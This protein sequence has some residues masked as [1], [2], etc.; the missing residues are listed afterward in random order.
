MATSPDTRGV[1]IQLNGS[2]NIS[3]YIDSIELLVTAA[4]GPFPFTS[5]IGVYDSITGQPLGS[6][7]FEIPAAGTLI[8]PIEEEYLAQKVFIGYDASIIEST[9]VDQYGSGYYEELCE[10]CACGVTNARCATVSNVLPVIQANINYESCGGMI[11]NY[12]VFCSLDNWV[13][14]NKKKVST[15]LYYLMGL[16]FWTHVIGSPRI[17]P[18]TLISQD[19]LDTVV[20]YCQANYEE[21]KN[22][23]SKSVTLKD[24]VC[25]PCDNVVKTKTMIF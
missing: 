14:R 13:C 17:N 15:A 8:V 20:K 5:Q 7:T 21:A 22:N 24:R 18:T 25:M 19:R 11:V 6:T 2:R 9:N 10:A 12:S 16:T 1:E 23:F 4:S 3:V